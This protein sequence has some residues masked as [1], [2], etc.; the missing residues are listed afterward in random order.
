RVFG[1]GYVDTRSDVLK[2]DNRPAALRAADHDDVKL[3][4][5]GAD[6][7]HVFHTKSAG[8]FDVVGWGVVQT[9][10]WGTLTQ[11]AGAFV[12]EAGWQSTTRALRPRISAGYSWG[13]G[14]S[15]PKRSTSS[16]V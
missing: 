1:I 13:S 16:T 2:T 6:Y 11:R 9:G 3:G 5:W 4:T 10:A 15:H 12:G 8:T 7:V 14:G